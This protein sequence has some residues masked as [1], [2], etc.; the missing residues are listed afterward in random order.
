MTRLALI[1]LFTAVFLFAPV[2]SSNADQ[3]NPTLWKTLTHS[4]DVNCVAF[5]TDGSIVASACA[6]HTVKLWAVS[7]GIEIRTLSGHSHKV[8]SVAFS[9][10]GSVFASAGGVWNNSQETYTSGEIILWEVISGRRIR[11]ITGQSKQI[12]SIAFSPDGGLLASG[13]SDKTTIIW[14]SSS[15]EQIRTL[16]GHSVP[17]NRSVSVRMVRG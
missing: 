17:S 2:T 8:M 12:A 15:G 7:T 5:S 10:D 13:S 11:T 16:A 1:S 9:P 14:N 3:L 4:D 6:D